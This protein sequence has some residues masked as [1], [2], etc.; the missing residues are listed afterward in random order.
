MADFVKDGDDVFSTQLNNFASGLTTLG[1][2]LGFTPTEITDADDDAVI[3]AYIIG[4]QSTVQSY[5]QDFTKYKLLARFGDGM[6]VLP[7]TVP[8]IAAFPVSPTVTAA[9]IEGRFRQRAA[10]AKSSSAYTTSKGETLNIVAP[11]EVFDPLTGKPTFSIYMDSGHPVLKWVKSKFQG[12]D[13]YKNDGTGTAWVKKE[14]DLKSPW[15]DTDDLPETGKSAVW[16]YK[17]I[18]IFNDKPT[19]EYSDEI[20]VTVYGSV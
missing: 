20:T 1:A 13:I 2:G 4:R 7:A 6:A 18:Y 14:R 10:K 15:A 9:N 11:D 19:G 8:V 16:K 3:F 12:V 17:M 5:G